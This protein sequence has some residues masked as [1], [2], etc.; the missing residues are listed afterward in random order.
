MI[1]TIEII[2]VDTSTDKTPKIVE[3]YRMLSSLG[4]KKGCRAAEMMGFML[5]DMRLLH[6]TDADC[7][8]PDTWLEI[9]NDAFKPNIAAVGGN[10]YLKKLSLVRKMGCCAWISCWRKHWA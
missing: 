3:A 5:L 8:V 6:F 1:V 10:A 4:R 9:L 2:V 7:I